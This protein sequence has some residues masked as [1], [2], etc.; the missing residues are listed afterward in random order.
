[1]DVSQDV[2][3]S[4]LGHAVKALEGEAQHFTRL[5]EYGT[6]V[7]HAVTERDRIVKQ[8]EE[9]EGRVTQ[10]RKDMETEARKLGDLRAETATET[11]RRDTVKAETDAQERRLQGLLGQIAAIKEKVGA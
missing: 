2:S 11:A 9:A 1:M 10:A 4:E 5:V 8:A 7:L 3:Q 6:I